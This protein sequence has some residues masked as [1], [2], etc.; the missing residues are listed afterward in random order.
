MR[1]LSSKVRCLF[2]TDGVRD[3]ANRG[4]MTPEVVLRIARAHVLFLTERG[5][6]R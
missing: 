6:P 3:V 4:V 2:G 5:T 1:T